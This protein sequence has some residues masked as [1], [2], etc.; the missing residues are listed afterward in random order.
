MQLF[1]SFIHLRFGLLGGE[2]YKM[3]IGKM[4]DALALFNHAVCELTAMSCF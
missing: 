4:S 3:C 2:I 1:D